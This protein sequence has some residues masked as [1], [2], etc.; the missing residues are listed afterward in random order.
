MTSTDAKKLWLGE[1]VT[2]PVYRTDESILAQTRLVL[3]GPSKLV[4]MAE[5]HLTSAML[6]FRLNRRIT[7]SVSEI[8]HYYSIEFKWV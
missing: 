4:E 3:V 2:V 5:K 8:C 1:T 7:Y 6:T